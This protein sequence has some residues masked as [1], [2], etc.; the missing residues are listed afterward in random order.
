MAVSGGYPAGY[1]KGYEITGLNKKFGKNTLVFQAGTKTEKG[2]VVTNG[3]RVFCVTSY[4]K[5][6]KMPWNI[7]RKSWK[8]TF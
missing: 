1:E 5:N 4:G 7:Q 6:I 8:N 3:G 2:K